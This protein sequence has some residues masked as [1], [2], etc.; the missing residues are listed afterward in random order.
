MVHWEPFLLTRHDLCWDLGNQLLPIVH[1]GRGSLGG[2]RPFL[3]EWGEQA[4]PYTERITNLT[5]RNG[6]HRAGFDPGALRWFQINS[7]ICGFLHNFSRGVVSIMFFSIHHGGGKATRAGA[8]FARWS[9]NG[10][11][12]KRFELSARNSS[13][14]SCHLTF[15][16]FISGEVYTLDLFLSEEIWDKN[17]WH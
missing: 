3:Q 15:F 17:H 1:G 8:G 13:H 12:F 14:R 7:S 11:K 16:S 5:S 2:R 10:H 6:S 4:R 9:V